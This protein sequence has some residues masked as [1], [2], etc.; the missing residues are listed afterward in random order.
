MQ[1]AS[2]VKKLRIV[3]I[4]EGGWICLRTEKNVQMCLQR[5]EKKIIQTVSK[6]RVVELYN[7]NGSKQFIYLVFFSHNA[8][9]RVVGKI[10]AA[11]FCQ[12]KII[13]S[14]VVVSGKNHLTVY[15]QRE[16]IA[17]EVQRAEKLWKNLREKKIKFVEDEI[18]AI[19]S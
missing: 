14:S 7:E 4:R 3:V 17:E 1:L 13:Y 19:S 5:E 15:S 6:V 16:K 18:R 12:L 2:I 10:F 8:V 11:F 9:F